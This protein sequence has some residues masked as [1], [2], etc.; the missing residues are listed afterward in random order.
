M[1]G[2][3]ECIICIYTCPENEYM[4]DVDVEVEVEEATM[5]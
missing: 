3:H 1:C 5:P 4:D 2:E